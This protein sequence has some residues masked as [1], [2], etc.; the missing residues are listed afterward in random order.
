MWFLELTWNKSFEWAKIHH[1][2]NFLL[3]TNQKNKHANFNQL[4]IKGINNNAFGSLTGK[5]FLT[6]VKECLAFSSSSKHLCVSVKV[7]QTKTKNKTNKG[8]EI[9]RD[10]QMLEVIECSAK[11]CTAI[12][13]AT[14]EED[15]LTILYY[16]LL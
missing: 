16:T 14:T 9:K 15:F 7:K 10:E 8:E 5:P 2:N 13:N 6:L 11:G 4:D 1:L 12:D 3:S